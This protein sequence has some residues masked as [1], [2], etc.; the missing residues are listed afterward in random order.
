MT[1]INVDEMKFPKTAVVCLSPNH[2]GMEISARVLASRLSQWSEGCV[3]VVRR[4]SWLER[5]ARDM[6]LQHIAISMKYHFSI[7]GIFQIRKALRDHRVRLMIYVGSSEMRTLRFS[8]NKKIDRFVV[9]HGTPKSNKK[10]DLAHRFLWSRVTH[11]WAVSEY[12]RLNVCELFPVQESSSF[13]NY[14]GQGEKLDELP[15]PL[16]LTSSSEKLCIGQVARVEYIKGQFDSLE[17]LRRIR[18][19]GIDAEIVFYGDGRN[20]EDLK[21]RVQEKNLLEH[22]TLAG[23]I[24]KPYMR[25]GQH[26]MFLYPSYSEGFG[27]SFT[28]AIS[29][30]IHCLCYNNSCFPEYRFLG[31]RYNMVPNGDIDALVQ[32]IKEIW[33]SKESQPLGNRDLARDIFSDQ[34]EII[35]LY[36][37]LY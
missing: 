33:E 11:H 7:T 8:V 9:R 12:I 19:S 26:H 5:I 35:R 18:E 16:P 10:T 36:K 24:R 20:M 37:A 3:F 21:S 23:Q 28:E 30:G 31:F 29:S 32:R 34:A 22:V 25:L 27:N 1:E 15:F 6:S 2:G 4:G 17:A 13:V 14:G